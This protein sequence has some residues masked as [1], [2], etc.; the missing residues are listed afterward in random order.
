MREEREGLSD[1]IGIVMMRA[2]GWRL[3]KMLVTTSHHP[4][5]ECEKPF[6]TPYPL[7]WEDIHSAAAAGL[8]KLKPTIPSASMLSLPTLDPEKR[9]TR[10]PMM[11]SL[12]TC[13]DRGLSRDSSI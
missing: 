13:R 12:P 11:P 10:L 2:G 5:D 4:S 1:V 3:G 6:T 7:T 8:K 9:E